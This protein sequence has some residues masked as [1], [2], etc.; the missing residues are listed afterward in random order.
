MQKGFWVIYFVILTAVAILLL[1]LNFKTISAYFYQFR[2]PATAVTIADLI[3]A[4]IEPKQEAVNQDLIYI[5]DRKGRQSELIPV[6]TYD[7][8]AKVAINARHPQSVKIG[9]FL[10]DLLTNDLVLVWGKIADDYYLKR[11]NFSHQFAYMTFKYKDPDL[12]QDPGQEYIFTHV[13]SNH[14]IAANTNLDHALRQL[15]KGDIVRLK[16]YLVNITGA[17]KTLINTSTVRTDNWQQGEG[18]T[19]GSE[20]IYVTELQNGDR[21]FK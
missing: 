15:Q 12:N 19:G 17:D 14:L 7:I 3:D 6:A 10:D 20:F 2:Y 21:L 5:T 11:I 13:S 8:Q 16:G 18:N 9:N 1:I 4:N